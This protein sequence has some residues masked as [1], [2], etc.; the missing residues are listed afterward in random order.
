MSL[1]HLITTAGHAAVWRLAYHMPLWALVLV[2]VLAVVW[3]R[4]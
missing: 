1:D 4:R 2:T 3:T